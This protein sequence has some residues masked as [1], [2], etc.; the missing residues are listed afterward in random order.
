MNTTKVNLKNSEKIKKAY[1]QERYMFTQ[2]FLIWLA[3]TLHA[4]WYITAIPF[5]NITL[6]VLCKV[7]EA[8]TKAKELD[9]E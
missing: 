3:I 8:G 4:P 2:I 7:F 5:L 1:L 6:W 9:D